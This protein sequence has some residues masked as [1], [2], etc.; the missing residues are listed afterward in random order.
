VKSNKAQQDKGFN[1]QQ[2]QIEKDHSKAK[3]AARQD[4]IRYDYDDSS[5]IK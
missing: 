3:E 4:G 5:D 1:N 2:D